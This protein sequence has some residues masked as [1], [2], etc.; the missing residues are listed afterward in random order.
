VIVPLVGPS[1]GWA[2]RNLVSLL[3][4]FGPFLAGWAISRQ[5]SGVSLRRL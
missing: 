3:L 4:G 5:G 1:F 2:A